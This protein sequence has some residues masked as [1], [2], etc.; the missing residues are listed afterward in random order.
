MPSVEGT[1]NT[2]RGEYEYL[3]RRFKLTRGA[4]SFLGGDELD[5]LLQLAAEHEVRIPGREALTIRIIVGGTMRDLEITFESDAQPPISQ[6]DLLSYLAFG[7]DA[8]TLIHGQGSPLSGQASGGGL[9]GNVAGVATQQFTAMALESMSSGLEAEL[10]RDLGLDVVRI[11]PAHLSADV[12]TGGYLD[13]L[14]GT[15]IELGRYMG[16]RMFVAAQARPVRA[17]PGVRLEYRT[18]RDFEWSATWR[19]RFVPS[20]PTL[21]QREANSVGV[22]GSFLFKEWRF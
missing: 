3:S 11:T 16:S 13:V 8:S 15:E 19:S 5:P 22:F 17:L 4:V 1:I 9:V 2:D 10:S 12:F 7:R 6:T 20:L 21:R 14:R 18:R